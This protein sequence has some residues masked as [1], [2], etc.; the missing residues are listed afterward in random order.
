MQ[1]GKNEERSPLPHE[2][3]KPCFEDWDCPKHVPKP[4]EGSGD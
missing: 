3:G 1:K 2:R 4:A